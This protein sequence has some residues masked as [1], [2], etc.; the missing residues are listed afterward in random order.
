M[1]LERSSAPGFG[2]WESR[3]PVQLQ[4]DVEK[5]R[6]EISR[7]HRQYDAV[8]PENRLVAR[9][10]ESRWEK[11]IHDAHELESRLDALESSERPLSDHQ[12]QRLLE[13]GSD[14]D[15]LW[16]DPRASTPLKQRILR[17]VLEEII[18]DVQDSPSE[19]VLH[20]HWAGGVHTTLRVPKNRKGRTLQ[21]TDRNVVDLMRELAKVC[22]DRKVAQILNRLGYR[23]GSGNTWKEARVRSHRRYHQIP[24]FDERNRES[25]LTLT[26]AAQTLRVNASVVRR[27]LADGI[28]PGRQVV[29]HA[30]WIIERKDL[31]LPDVTAAIQMVHEG[32]RKPPRR[33]PGQMELPF[34][35]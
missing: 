32:R 20:L 29:P 30:P 1:S 4:A 35:Q 11:T 2:R 21:C 12:R 8:D 24:R 7:A 16:N 9:E 28:L 13:L 31:E 5:A 15:L 3:P 18:V 23:T 33:V 6:Y 27:L 26:D 34:N 10:L 14:L 19:A 22:R 25:W 17:T